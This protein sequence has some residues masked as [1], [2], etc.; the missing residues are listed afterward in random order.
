MDGGRHGTGGVVTSFSAAGPTAFGHTLKPDVAAPGG[1]ILSSS[2]QQFTGGSPFVAID[3]TSMSSPHVAGAAALLRQRH[4]DWNV[5]QVKSALMSTAGSAWGNTART[6][7][8]SA[9]LQGAGFVNIPAADDPK[10]F[11][12]PASLSFGD[13]RVRRGSPSSSCSACA[14]PATGPG[15]G[16]SS[17]SH[18]PRA[19]ASESSAFAG[20]DRPR[21]QL[22]ASR[23]RSSAPQ[24]RPRGTTSAIS[25]CESGHATRAL[26]GI[27]DPPGTCFGTGHATPPASER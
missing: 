24:A 5:R 9:L 11:T 18:S 8:A 15:R 10:L 23:S 21:R 1:E 16:R 27:R 12:E 2:L 7:E 4:R 25:C 3:G 14:M 19:R 26:C 17:C 13:L 20:L 22:P 6:Q